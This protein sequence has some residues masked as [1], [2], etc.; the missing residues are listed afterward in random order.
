VRLPEH[1][2]RHFPA[3]PDG[4]YAGFHPADSAAAL[5]EL[6]RRISDAQYL[7]IPASSFWWLDYYREFADVLNTRYERVWSDADCVIFRLT[8]RRAASV[9]VKRDSIPVVPQAPAV[10]GNG[11]AKPREKSRERVR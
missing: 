4:R 7:L 5:Q 3:T 10:R 6:D 2:G 1:T 8:T 9:I 11:H